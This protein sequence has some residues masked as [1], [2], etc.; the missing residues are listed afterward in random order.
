MANF[1]QKLGNFVSGKKQATRKVASASGL[2]VNEQT[3]ASTTFLEYL[4]DDAVLNSNLKQ[5][6]DGVFVEP[7]RLDVPVDSKLSESKLEDYNEQLDRVN[8]AQKI[9]DAY[10]ALWHNGNI[11]FEMDVIG[12]RLIGL[13]EIDANSMKVKETDEGE[14]IGY[15]Q[16]GQGIA[17]VEFPKE[18]IL[19][20]RAPSLKTGALGQPLLTPLKY[21]LARKVTA[22]NFLSGM[23]A[24]LQPLIYLN[25]TDSTDEAIK[26]IQ[27]EL[28]AAKDPLNPLKIITLL[29]N[30]DVGRV[31]T[32]TT[33]DFKTIFD[34]IDRQNDEIIR[35]VQIPP[36]VA[37]T[38]D[39]S[40]RSNSEIQERAVFGRTASAWQNFFV[41]AL[42]QEFLNK[43]KW[44]DVKFE[45]PIED[46]RKQ[47]A[48]LVRATKLKDLGYSQEAIHK[49]LI[50]NG[51][52][53]E[54]DFQEMDIEGG[55]PINEDLS[56]Y[57]SRKP[58]PKDGIPQNEA[59]RQNDIKNGTKKESQ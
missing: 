33:S 35:V 16:E 22:E 58:R 26:D 11:F 3:N 56:Q 1:I 55:E 34:Y 7:I 10:P 43:I 46:E 29:E 41:N 5:L 36:I 15:V 40:N 37:G 19:H 39:N 32:G 18:K 17:K 20:I 23:V 51:I 12:D 48:A 6:Q 57:E 25:L 54:E 53:V 2:D 21:P 9:K 13:Y 28:K 8:F 27:K 49:V 4:D 50:E 52:K 24:N 44:T 38:V 45:F 31:D 59:Q 14:I 42:Q 30:E 47:E